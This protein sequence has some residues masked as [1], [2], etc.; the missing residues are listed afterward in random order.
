MYSVSCTDIADVV[1][2]LDDSTVKHARLDVLELLLVRIEAHNGYRISK[3]KLFYSLTSTESSIRIC[4]VQNSDIA[5]FGQKLLSLLICSL[6]S[7]AALTLDEVGTDIHRAALSRA[8]GRTALSR[9][10]NSI[11]LS[12]LLCC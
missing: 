7:T 12:G 2:V 11:S 4:C 1:R 5:V 10:L 3:I 8:L 6:L 9:F